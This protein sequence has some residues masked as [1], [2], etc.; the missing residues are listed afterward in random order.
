MRDLMVGR[1]K[2]LV[3]QKSVE[4]RGSTIATVDSLARERRESEEE[5]RSKKSFRPYGS[6]DESR[7]PTTPNAH[8]LTNDSQQPTPDAYQQN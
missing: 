8:F 1:E 2:R 6:H 5:K 7:T 3:E 4:W